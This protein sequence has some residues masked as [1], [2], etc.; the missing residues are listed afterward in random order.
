MVLV[1]YKY[2]YLSFVTPK[3]KEKIMMQLPVLSILILQFKVIV[4]NHT[5]MCF[6][7]SL[8]L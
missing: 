2:M 3:N 7:S 4:N 6:F 5:V 8:D 1:A